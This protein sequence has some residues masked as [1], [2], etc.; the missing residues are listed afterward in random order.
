MAIYF[1]R[2]PKVP[3]PRVMSLEQDLSLVLDEFR[4]I[5]LRLCE[6]QL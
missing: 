2:C 1:G 4:L 3:L 5:S 6:F